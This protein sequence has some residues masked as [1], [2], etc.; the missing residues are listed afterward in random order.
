MK[1]KIGVSGASSPCRTRGAEPLAAPSWMFAG[2]CG[3]SAGW[4]APFRGL[5]AGSSLPGP[6][7]QEKAEL[8]AVEHVLCLPTQ[9]VSCSVE[10]PRLVP[11]NP[12][13]GR[14]LCSA[15]LCPSPAGSRACSF[16]LLPRDALFLGHLQVYTPTRRPLPWQTPACTPQ[17]CPCPRGSPRRSSCSLRLTSR[18]LEW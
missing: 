2:P 10:L 17:Q 14:G 7:A 1:E 4:A 13:L 16:L 11:P 12:E 8:G 15:A 6:V 18:P 9:I 3:A 5:W